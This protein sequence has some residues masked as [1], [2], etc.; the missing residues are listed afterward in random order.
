MS[1]TMALAHELTQMA[2]LVLLRLCY[3]NTLHHTH[4]VNQEQRR[5]EAERIFR[6]VM[7][8]SRFVLWWGR[9]LVI[10]IP[11]EFMAQVVAHELV[12]PGGGE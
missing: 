8:R 3:I 2:V 5:N 11:H 7:W 4:G 6:Y 9:H 10:H 1:A 12:A